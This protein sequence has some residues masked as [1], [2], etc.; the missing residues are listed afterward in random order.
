MADGQRLRALTNPA[1]QEFATAAIAALSPT[2]PILGPLGGLASIIG[3]FI[4]GLLSQSKKKKFAVRL[5]GTVNRERYWEKRPAALYIGRRIRSRLKMPPGARHLLVQRTDA[6]PPLPSLSSVADE[7]RQGAGV[8]RGPLERVRGDITEAARRR[9]PEDWP[10]R[11]IRAPGIRRG[12]CPGTPV[13]ESFRGRGSPCVPS[14]DSVPFEVVGLV[15]GSEWLTFEEIEAARSEQAFREREKSI[16]D[17]RAGTPVPGAERVREAKE[18]ERMLFQFGPI[19]GEV[20]KAGIRVGERF[21]DAELQSK[22]NREQRR[23]IQQTPPIVATPANL[24][25]VP[26]PRRPPI[27][28]GTGVP[29]AIEG[30]LD[31]LGR[32]PGQV[33]EDLG[34]RPSPL[35]RRFPDLNGAAPGVARRGVPGQ[36]IIVRPDGTATT[37]PRDC[38]PPKGS[39]CFVFRPARTTPARFVRCKQRRMN[40]LNPRAAGR[41]AR[42]LAA[43][44]RAMKRIEGAM[45]E[46]AKLVR[47]PKP[48]AP[49]KKKR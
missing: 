44:G 8:F 22:L 4:E 28:T 13:P 3:L 15:V 31:G 9:F 1:V 6:A 33:I 2:A 43:A 46:C 12:T 30:L 48:R 36:K 32:I 42:R 41:A 19:L 35:A 14:W 45:K 17:A 5:E 34:V 18:T 26:G 16:E 49:A 11:D 29:E 38:P 37:L 21:L 7:V 10:Y 27:G 20:I 39:C 40:P 25:A 47:K 24:P 23:L